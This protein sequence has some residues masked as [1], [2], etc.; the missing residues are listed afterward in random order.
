MGMSDMNRG[1]H[2]EKLLNLKSQQVV[3]DPSPLNRDA[4]APPDGSK[5][6]ILVDEIAALAHRFWEEEGRPEGKAAEHWQ[7][8]VETLQTERGAG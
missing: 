5:D 3:E 6:R 4:P 8:A 7:R 1:L 2:R